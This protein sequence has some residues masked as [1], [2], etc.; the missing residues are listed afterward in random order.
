MFPTCHYF[1][2]ANGPITLN[3][4]KYGDKRW[5][6]LNF[7]L[8]HSTIKPVLVTSFECIT[9]S[10]YT[11]L[12]HSCNCCGCHTS[13]ATTNA[14]QLSS[15]FFFLQVTPYLM[16]D[17][18]S[19]FCSPSWHRDNV[20]D[21][22][23]SLLKPALVSNYNVSQLSSLLSLILLSVRTARYSFNNFECMCHSVML[24]TF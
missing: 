19:I 23:L 24:R 7:L 13:T 18:I 22:R 6:A 17:D 3:S 16:L 5:S 14:A 8:S 20:N 12:L 21:A 2:C 4:G 15:L 11:A 1:L 10:Q 9:T